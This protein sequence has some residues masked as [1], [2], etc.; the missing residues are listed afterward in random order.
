MV[1]YKSHGR[2]DISLGCSGFHVLSF[3]DIYGL[4]RATLECLDMSLAISVRSP[5]DNYN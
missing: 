4:S 1:D 5:S 2:R 3:G